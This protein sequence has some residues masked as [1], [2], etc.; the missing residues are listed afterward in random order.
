VALFHA[1][2]VRR[3]SLQSLPLTEVAH[4]SRGHIA[5]LWLVTGVLHAASRILSPP[6][7]STPTLSRGCLDSPDDY[8]LPF[9]APKHASRSPWIR[10]TEPVRSASFIHFEA[11]ILL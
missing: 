4:P 1:T 5:P 9:H 8:G 7:S 11:L 10:A 6:V 3:F 2:A